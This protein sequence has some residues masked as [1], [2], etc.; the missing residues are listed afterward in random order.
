MKYLQEILVSRF[1]T[2]NCLN[3][4]KMKR[5]VYYVKD[6]GFRLKVSLNFYRFFLSSFLCYESLN[7]CFYLT[8]IWDF[9]ARKLVHWNAEKLFMW[10]DILHFS[11]KVKVEFNLNKK[12]IF[13]NSLN[14]ILL[15]QISTKFCHSKT[16]L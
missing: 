8:F 11:N 12:F 2:L 4:K 14:L 3:L 10:D 5:M 6:N 13:W 1:C 9:L 7:W 16:K 15:S